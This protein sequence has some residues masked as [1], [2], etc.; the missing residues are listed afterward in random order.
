MK[1]LIAVVLFFFC[2]S[3]VCNA[4][5][6]NAG[7]KKIALYVR[8]G[9][10]I[11][12]HIPMSYLTSDDTQEWYHAYNIGVTCDYRKTEKI[13]MRTG[14]LYSA[15]GF[16]DVY[17]PY[18]HLNYLEMPVLAVFQKPLGN[19]VNL[20]AQAG[21]YFAYGIGGERKEET[22]NGDG[23]IYNKSFKDNYNGRPTYKR[24]DWGWNVGAGINVGRVYIGCAYEVSAFFGKRHTNHCIMANL[25]F[26]IL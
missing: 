16:K 2:L 13:L 15:K 24:F 12:N 22:A 10:N 6:D 23:Y 26:Q 17:V 18:T 5:E 21:I 3:L 14:V 11:T 7:E 1:R 25:G 9:L 4:Q 19:L 8:G 20:E